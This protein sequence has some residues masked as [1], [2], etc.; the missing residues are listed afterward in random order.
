M[1][2]FSLVFTSFMV[3][4]STVQ[5]GETFSREGNNLVVRNNEFIR[6][7]A[8]QKAWYKGYLFYWDESKTYSR[9]VQAVPMED[10]QKTFGNRMAVHCKN[11]HR[12]T[13]LLPNHPEL[14]KNPFNVERPRLG[15]FPITAKDIE[16]LRQAQGGGNEFT[17]LTPKEYWERNRKATFTHKDNE[18]LTQRFGPFYSA[19]VF[20]EWVLDLEGNRDFDARFRYNFNHQSRLGRLPVIQGVRIL[21]APGYMEDPKTSRVQQ[22][23]RALK[24]LGLDVGTFEMNS[25]LSLEQNSED[26]LRSIQKERQE[27]RKL[28]LMGASKGS[29]E[30]LAALIKAEQRHIDT[31]HILAVIS[32]SG[33]VRGSFLAD[34]ILRPTIFKIAEAFL[35]REARKTGYPFKSVRPGLESQSS[36]YLSSYFKE[37]HKMIP[38]DISYYQL[39]G[40]PDRKVVFAKDGFFQLLLKYLIDTMIFPKSYA[41]DGFLE[42]PSMVM[43][44]EWDLSVKTVVLNGTHSLTDGEFE[45]ISLSNKEGLR[46]FI[47]AYILTVLEDLRY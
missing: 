5:A 39:I 44:T 14:L 35:S 11:W 2:F 47:G 6:C 21:V 17:T 33:T 8:N 43:P 12:L 18:E 10:L 26:I 9:V 40:V 20:K 7:I 29:P 4:A 25:L 3:F 1:S 23:I 19:D 46:R 34:W 36:E 22:M 37:R 16:S 27:G 28:V 24:D 15:A 31:S 32:L 38:K 45:G 30:I 42:Y 41:F 13:Q